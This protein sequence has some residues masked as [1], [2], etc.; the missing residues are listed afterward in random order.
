[1]KWTEDKEDQLADLWKSGETAMS[2]GRKMEISRNAVMGKVHRMKLPKRDDMT[3]TYNTAKIDKETGLKEHEARKAGK[4]KRGKPA[5][6]DVTK[7]FAKDGPKSMFDLK[8]K[9][10]K[11]PVNQSNNHRDYLFCSAPSV[12]NKPYCNNHCLTS[13]Q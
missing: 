13:Y 9:E 10:C 4:A 7:S 8:A 12:E 11:W 3:R 1:M 5:P 6:G 2:I